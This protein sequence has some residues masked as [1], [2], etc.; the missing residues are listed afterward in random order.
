LARP[1][2]HATNIARLSTRIAQFFGNDC[3]QI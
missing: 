1:G 2:L 3:L